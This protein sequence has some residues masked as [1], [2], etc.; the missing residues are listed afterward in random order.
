M[1]DIGF[2]KYFINKDK[3]MIDAIW[4]YSINDKEYSGTGIVEG[5]FN[6]S[7]EG[8]FN[9]TYFNDEGEVT[10]KY[11]MEVIKK[12]G[13]Y[14]LIWTKGE[15]VLYTGIGMMFNGILYAGWRLLK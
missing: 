8:N 5:D 7:F 11:E 14:K 1:N 6:E 4:V 12:E 9:V 15:K 13:H 3:N 2:V 10:H